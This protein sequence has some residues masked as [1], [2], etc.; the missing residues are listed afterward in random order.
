[1]APKTGITD[2]VLAAA[3]RHFYFAAIREALE[4]F[5]QIYIQI[6]IAV[7]E[8]ANLI[9]PEWKDELHIIL[10]ALSA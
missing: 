3:R 2:L 6:D 4:T 10:P 7:K 9:R 5:S 1:L 8:R